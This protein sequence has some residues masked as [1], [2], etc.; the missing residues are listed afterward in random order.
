[1]HERCSVVLLIYN[2]ND[3][4]KNLTRNVLKK[5]RYRRA[6][7]LVLSRIM[8]SMMAILGPRAKRFV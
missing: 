1:M 4:Y 2:V 3:Y 5:N 7:M 6:D 8:M